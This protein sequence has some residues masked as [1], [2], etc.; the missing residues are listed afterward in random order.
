MQKS[1]KMPTDFRPP[2]RTESLEVPEELKVNDFAFE[3]ENK[4]KGSWRIMQ[5]E[6]R[7]KRCFPNESCSSVPTVREFYFFFPRP[8]IHICK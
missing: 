5:T 1:A 8:G 3:F 2:K 4:Q 6:N 7:R